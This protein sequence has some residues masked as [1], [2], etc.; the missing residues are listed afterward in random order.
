L[1]RLP[2]PAGNALAGPAFKR[3]EG[4]AKELF[5]RKTPQLLAMAATLALGTHIAL[6]Q[7]AKTGDSTTAQTKSPAD[8][9]SSDGFTPQESSPANGG[10]NLRSTTGQGSAGAPKLPAGQ[11]EKIVGIF[12]GHKVAAARI[13]VP[14]HQGIQ[15]PSDL[16]YHPLPADVVAVNPEWRGY[17]FI[18]VA[19]EVLIVDPATREIVEILQL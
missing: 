7:G 6:A 2:P 8:L 15:L 10:I 4:S 5:M 19:N 1:S 9:R 3:K 11:R 14:V 16:E 17:N 13:D 18:V 12:R